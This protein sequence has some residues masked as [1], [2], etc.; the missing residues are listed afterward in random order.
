L[1]IDHVRAYERIMSMLR[2][3]PS[4]TGSL[5]IFLGFINLASK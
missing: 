2:G 5:A 3:C 1:N 4:L